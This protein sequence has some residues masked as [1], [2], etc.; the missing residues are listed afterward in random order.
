[1]AH[2]LCTG[3]RGNADFCSRRVRCKN[4]ALCITKIKR[5]DFSNLSAFPEIWRPSW[6]GGL[7]YD[8][9]LG[10]RPSLTWPNFFPIVHDRD[11]IINREQSET[12]QND[13]N[14]M[15]VYVSEY[16]RVCFRLY[17]DW[18]RPFLNIYGHSAK[19]AIQLRIRANETKWEQFPRNRLT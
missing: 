18:L 7:V 2:R 15:C 5:N 6:F 3:Q 14:A 12:N 11:K 19:E 17:E 8:D 16:L 10:L 4:R 9:V 13:E 1:M